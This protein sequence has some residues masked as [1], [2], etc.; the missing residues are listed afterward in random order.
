MLRSLSLIIPAAYLPSVLTPVTKS[1]HKFESQSGFKS[2]Y[3]SRDKSRDKFGYTAGYNS[4]RKSPWVLGLMLL[5]ALLWLMLGA[6]PVAIAAQTEGTVLNYTQVFLNDRDFSNQ[7]L[8]G[9]S[10]AGVQARY[11]RF[12]HTNLT[13]AI[14][15]QGTFLNAS[16]QGA[17]LTGALADRVNWEG[18]DLSDAVLVDMIATR[19]PFTGATIT[20]ADF[21]GA[22]LDLYEVKQLCQRAEGT[23]STTGVETR[24]SLGCR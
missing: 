1:G 23:N 19:T 20:G 6:A 24:D 17:N 22:I 10:F 5:L 12:E 21:S 3:K 9:A 8:T 14:L 16:F 4:R 7:D 11:I 2:R 13:N 18:A 15:T